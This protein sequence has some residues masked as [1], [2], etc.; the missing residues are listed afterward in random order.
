MS[1]NR[2]V[3]VPGVFF[4]HGMG[5]ILCG[6]PTHPSHK[7][8]N[9]RVKLHR[10]VTKVRQTCGVPSAFGVSIKKSQLYMVTGPEYQ[11]VMLLGDVTEKLL[12]KSVPDRRKW[13]V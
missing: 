10:D 2:D 1:K 9:A 12:D 4:E 11:V 5:Y 8:V 3:R 6:W 13:T 7:W